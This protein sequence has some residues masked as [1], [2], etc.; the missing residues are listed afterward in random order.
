MLHDSL[1]L[2]SLGML[3]RTW[4]GSSPFVPLPVPV[5]VSFLLEPEPGPEPEPEPFLPEPD[6]EPDA[7]PEPVGTFARGRIG[8]TG[9]GGGGGP[10]SYSCVVLMVCFAL[11]FPPSGMWIICCQ[12]SLNFGLTSSTSSRTRVPPGGA[13]GLPVYGS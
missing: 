13:S 1:F 3:P 4:T 5:A 2:G 12:L 8:S 9:P 11:P 10:S 7:E 6:A